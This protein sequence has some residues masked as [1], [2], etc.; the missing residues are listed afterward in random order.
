MANTFIQMLKNEFNLSELETRILQMTTRQLQRTDRR[1]YFQHIKPRE[2]NFKIYLR[3]VY[4]S[5]DPVLQKQWLDNVVQN[6]LSR[7]GEPDIADSLVMDIIGRLAVYNHMRIRAE[8]EGVK[9]NRLANF[10]GM[11][12]LIMLVGAVTAFVMYLL[13]R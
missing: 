11:G 6:M 12:A 8:E 9:I 7:G 10:G 1:Y 4:D 3:G 2:K 13:A 5:L